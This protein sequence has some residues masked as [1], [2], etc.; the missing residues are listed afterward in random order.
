[1]QKRTITTMLD[2]IFG[3]MF[4][5]QWVVFV[6]LVILLVG[7]SELAWRMGLASS[8]EEIGSGQGQRHSAVCGAGSIGV[9]AWIQFRHRCR[10]QRGA[11]R[12]SG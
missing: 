12:T 6:G 8:T 11:S 4:A 9:I 10:P 7:L 1:P 2:Q 5:S 3:R